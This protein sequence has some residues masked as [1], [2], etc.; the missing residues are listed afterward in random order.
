MTVIESLR[1]GSVMVWLTSV[2]AVGKA[3]GTGWDVGDAAGAAVV[4][5]PWAYR[6][7]R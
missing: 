3:V 1:S 7:V 4:V 5:V 6:P 2:N